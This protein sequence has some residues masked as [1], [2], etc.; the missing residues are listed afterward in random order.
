MISSSMVRWLMI[1]KFS[2]IEVDIV[3]VVEILWD[4]VWFNKFLSRVVLSH[5]V[6]IF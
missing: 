4:E 2:R 3:L 1:G 6:V 5:L